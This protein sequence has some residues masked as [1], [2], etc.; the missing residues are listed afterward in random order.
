MSEPSKASKFTRADTELIRAII[1][2]VSRKEISRMVD[3]EA[4]GIQ[5]GGLKL[6]AVNKWW[7][8]LNIKMRK[9]GDADEAEEAGTDNPDEFESEDEGDSDDQKITTAKTSGGKVVAKE[10][11]GGKAVAKETGNGKAAAKKGSRKAP[12]KNK[13]ITAKGK[14]GKIKVTWDA[15]R[16]EVAADAV[17]KEKGIEEDVDDD[18]EDD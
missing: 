14:S 1:E 9:E 12:V 10:A 18:D 4:I 8:R 13:A 17:A 5:L 6:A 16:A 2:Q 7:S 15:V 11:G 3:W